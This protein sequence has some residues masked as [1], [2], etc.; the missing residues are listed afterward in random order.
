MFAGLVSYDW[1][2]LVVV[3]SRASWTRS[4]EPMTSTMWMDLTALHRIHFQNSIDCSAQMDT[5][6]GDAV[7]PIAVDYLQDYSFIRIK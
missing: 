5:H 2:N 7:E 3:E 1:Q 6:F 4:V